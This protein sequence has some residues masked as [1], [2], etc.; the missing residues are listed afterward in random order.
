MSAIL[1]TIDNL[2]VGQSAIYHIGKLAF[3]RGYNLE[4]DIVASRVLALSTADFV[5]IS[6]KGLMEGK[7]SG[8]L[9]LFQRP[10]AIGGAWEYWARRIKRRAYDGSN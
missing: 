3:D 1:D 7:G 8:E 6:Q 9:E 5:R 10:A 4:L 2:K